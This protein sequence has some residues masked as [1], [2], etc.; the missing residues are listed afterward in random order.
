[1]FASNTRTTGACRAQAGKGAAA[2]S[3]GQT[4]TSWAATTRAAAEAS[5]QRRVM[6]VP[7]VTTQAGR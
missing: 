6:S 7:A 3:S 2:D 1:M 5:H 4:N